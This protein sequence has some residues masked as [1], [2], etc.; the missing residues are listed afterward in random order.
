MNMTDT[1]PFEDS[2][3]DWRT[4]RELSENLDRIAYR[5]A[6]AGTLTEFAALEALASAAREAT[7]GAALALADWNGTEIA[8]LRAFGI[9]HGV[10]LRDLSAR[11]QAHLLARLRDLGT[12]VLVA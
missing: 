5:I 1:A 3:V 4:G 9:V 8:R 12:L 7:P 6:D 10:V 11:Q 2:T